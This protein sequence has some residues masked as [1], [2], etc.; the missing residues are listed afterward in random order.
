MT[1]EY[2]LDVAGTE[3]AGAASAG[4]LGSQ[5]ELE[6]VLVEGRAWVKID[7]GAWTEAAPADLG[8]EDVLDVWRYVARRGDLQVE[9]R[10]ADGNFRFR[11]TTPL[12]YETGSMRESGMTGQITEQVLVLTPEGV[13]VS[14]E[15][16][17]EAS[18]TI[19]EQKLELTGTT[20]IEFSRWGEPITIEPPI[21]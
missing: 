10:D 5:V 12:P 4:S 8:S 2:D 17:I 6:L 21:R 14:L 11:S 18:G 16:A 20:A 15:L 13:P 3:F 19:G 7:D 9:D 1:A